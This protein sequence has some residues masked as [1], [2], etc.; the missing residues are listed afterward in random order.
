MGL[1]GDRVVHADEGLGRDDRRYQHRAVGGP[2][3]ED[4]NEY[5]PSGDDGG[6]AAEP[7]DG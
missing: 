2:N 5:T 7:A 3:S 6:L 4:G 1:S